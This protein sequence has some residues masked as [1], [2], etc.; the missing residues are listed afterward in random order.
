M[1]KICYKNEKYDICSDNSRTDGK[2]FET[3]IGLRPTIEENTNLDLLSKN[4]HGV[5][6]V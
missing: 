6:F 2:V 4:H 5:K 1:Y 3:G